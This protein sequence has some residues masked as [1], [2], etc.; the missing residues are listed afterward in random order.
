MYGKPRPLVLLNLQETFM[1]LLF[2]LFSTR[3]DHRC[4]LYLQQIHRDGIL[5]LRSVEAKGDN[6]RVRTEGFQI[7]LLLCRRVTTP[8]DYPITY[9]S[10]LKPAGAKYIFHGGGQT[11]ST[12]TKP[13][14]ARERRW[15][16]K[17]TNLR[18]C[19]KSHRLAMFQALEEG[20]LSLHR[21]SKARLI[22]QLSSQCI[23]LYNSF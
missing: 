22:N 1:E 14:S 17:P 3:V 23:W 6:T 4:R 9:E 13:R 12:W 5:C 18:S 2:A 15:P 16:A 21:S 10:K 11:K 20:E 8:P 19:H 7:C